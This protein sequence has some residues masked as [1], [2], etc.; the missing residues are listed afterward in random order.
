MDNVMPV[1]GGH[2]ATRRLR[3]VPGLESLPIIALSASASAAERARSLEVG[4]SGFLAKPV[5]LSRLVE[6]IGRLLQLQWTVDE[7]L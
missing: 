6:E 2:E 5:V 1:M 3:G 7:R 4:A